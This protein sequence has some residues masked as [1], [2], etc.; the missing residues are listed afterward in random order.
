MLPFLYIIFVFKID[1][2]ILEISKENFIVKF[3][4]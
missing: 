3:N 1:Y 4:S 2:N